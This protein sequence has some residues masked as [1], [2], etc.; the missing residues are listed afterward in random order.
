MST[1]GRVRQTNCKIPRGSLLLTPPPTTTTTTTS[2]SPLAITLH[3]PIVS[4]LFSRSTLLFIPFS[5]PFAILSRIATCFRS[6]AATPPFV[7]QIDGVPLRFASELMWESARPTSGRPFRSGAMGVV[8][9]YNGF[10][11]PPWCCPT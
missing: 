1:N 3:R 8:R 6:P 11:Q 9:F 10:R 4:L 2:P 5:S 7:E